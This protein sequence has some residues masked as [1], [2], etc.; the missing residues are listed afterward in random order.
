M[1]KELKY[2]LYLLEDEDKE[3]YTNISTKLVSYSTTILP[4]LEDAYDES[5]IT[6]NVL[7][8]ERLIQVMDKINY[9]LV[10]KSFQNWLQNHPNDLLQAMILIAKYQYRDLNEQ[11][12]QENIE[13]IVNNI[14]FEISRYNPPLQSVSIINKVLYDTYE[15]TTVA[16]KENA[17]KHFA[18]NH[19]L[20]LKKGVPVSIAILYLI[21]ASKLDI[22]I[23]G[24]LLNNNLVLAYFKRHGGWKKPAPKLQFY[25]NPQD[26]GAIFTSNTLK[27][28]LHESKIPFQPSYDK[29]ACNL[30]IIKFALEHLAQTYHNAGQYGKVKDMQ[31]WVSELNTALS[32]YNS[33]W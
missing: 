2:L 28:Y 27:D 9:E 1:Q 24:I 22:P 3:V 33:N 19:I 16:N 14:D 18:L 15:F 29:P 5:L 32:N 11:R 21:I 4:Q 26:K 30:Q 23:S 6:G 7:L 20:S 8:E 25:I 12:I 31:A 17:E 10:S 13:E